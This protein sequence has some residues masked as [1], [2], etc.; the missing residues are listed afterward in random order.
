MQLQHQTSSRGFEQHFDDRAFLEKSTKF[1]STAGRAVIRK[2]L[3]L[4]HCMKDNDTPQWAKALIV[5]ALGYYLL[6]PNALN[7]L[8]L[9]VSSPEDAGVISSALLTVGMYVREKHWKQAE[10]TLQKSADKSVDAAAGK[11][12]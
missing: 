5:G 10:Q 2:N 9:G 12:T 1:A 6:S 11:H 7:D 4:Y 3:A 8:M